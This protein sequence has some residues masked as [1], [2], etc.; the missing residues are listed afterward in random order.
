MHHTLMHNSQVLAVCLEARFPEYIDA[1]TS[2]EQVPCMS[3][4]VSLAASLLSHA[5]GMLKSVGMQERAGACICQTA[6]GH[7]G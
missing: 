4:C 5:A 1:N 2:A 7:R 6:T 3:A